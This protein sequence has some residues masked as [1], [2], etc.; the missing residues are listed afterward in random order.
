LSDQFGAPAAVRTRFARILQRP[1]KADDAEFPNRR[2]WLELPLARII[3]RMVGAG[4]SVEIAGQASQESRNTTIKCV[5]PAPV[6]GIHAFTASPRE[7]RGWPGQARPIHA[8]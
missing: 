4:S 6:A 1:P 3:H 7:R 8:N 2:D 5:M